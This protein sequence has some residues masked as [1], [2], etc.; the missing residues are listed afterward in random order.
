MADL[1]LDA[2]AKAYAERALKN[3]KVVKTHENMKMIVALRKLQAEDKGKAPEDVRV[4]AKTFKAA[5]EAFVKTAREIVTFFKVP[6][7]DCPIWEKEPQI[8]E[9][10]V[11]PATPDLPPSLDTRSHWLL[12]TSIQYQGPEVM[13]KLGPNIGTVELAWGMERRHKADAG[14]AA[15]VVPPSPV[16]SAPPVAQALVAHP[17]GQVPT[18]VSTADCGNPAPGQQQPRVAKRQSSCPESNEEETKQYID[19]TIRSFDAKRLYSE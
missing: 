14:G 1:Q 4:Q 13:K 12:K 17:A 7:V 3:L 5:K 18:R 9:Y 15:A 10:M 19:G 16:D 2:E 6:K 11:D 8:R